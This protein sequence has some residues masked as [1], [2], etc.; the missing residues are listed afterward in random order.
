M[1]AAQTT[2]P[3]PAKDFPVVNDN[4]PYASFLDS[5]K[6]AHLQ[7][8]GSMFSQSTLVPT[9]LQGKVAD[10]TILVEM[11][12]R[13]NQNPLAFLQKCYVVHGKPGMEATLVIALMNVSG[14]F[15]DPIDY[16]V[17]GNDPKD[18]NYRVRAFAVRKSTGKRIDGPWLDWPTVKAEGWLDKSGSKWKTMPALMFMYRAAAWFS[19]AHCPEATMGMMMVEEL[20]DIEEERPRKDVTPASGTASRTESLAAQLSQSTNTY[21]DAP[22]PTEREVVGVQQAEEAQVNDAPDTKPDPTP[23]DGMSRADQLLIRMTEVYGCTD[24]QARKTLDAYA[25]KNFSRPFDVAANKDVPF[26]HMS[27]RVNK[28]DIPLI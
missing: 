10:C 27:E 7:R 25:I 12:L 17:E 11:A 8:L 18:P 15:K 23:S 22:K 24:E 14:L 16:E 28:K 1:T 20:R 19:R 6:F 21:V 26:N 13:L 4:G 3:S 2:L 5:N 9:H